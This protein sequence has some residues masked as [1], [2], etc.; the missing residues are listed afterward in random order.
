MRNA[1]FLGPPII[2]IRS[3]NVSG[4]NSSRNQL[5]AS[6]STASRRRSYSWR[7]NCALSKGVG[8]IRYHNH[9]NRPLDIRQE[10]RVMLLSDVE[11]S[12]MPST[13]LLQGTLDLLI[14]KTL[15]ME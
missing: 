14:L 11:R 9:P 12:K 15:S 13:D 2:A 5:R 3:A 4:L 7:F 10:K 8:I 6:R 1:E